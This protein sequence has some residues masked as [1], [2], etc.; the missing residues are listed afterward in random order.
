MFFPLYFPIFGAF[1]SFVVQLLIRFS[2][3]CF[4]IS[5]HFSSSSLSASFEYQ[6]SIESLMYLLPS[7]YASS[8]AFQV[9]WRKFLLSFNVF[10]RIGCWHLL[11]WLC[12]SL[13]VL[14]VNIWISLRH[15]SH[16]IEQF[17][18]SKFD[19]CSM[20]ILK[21]EFSAFVRHLN[22]RD[23]D[24]MEM[25]MSTLTTTQCDRALEQAPKKLDKTILILS[26]LKKDWKKTESF[27]AWVFKASV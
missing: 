26:R 27:L 14:T 8:V 3:I 24:H 9:T 19:T 18:K 5:F 12:I 23:R 25:D 15:E 4:A 13:K 10:F 11:R 22:D 7:C 17:F 16:F 1:A 20:R 21:Y 6:R 2:L